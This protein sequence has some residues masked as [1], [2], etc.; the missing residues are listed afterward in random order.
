LFAQQQLVRIIGLFLLLSHRH[1]LCTRAEGVFLALCARAQWVPDG[2]PL[3]RLHPAP[4][5]SFLLNLTQSFFVLFLLQKLT[6]NGEAGAF[7]MGGY[8]DN[9]PLCA[10]CFVPFLSEKLISVAQF[11]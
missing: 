8:Y 5:D 10:L 11:D 7:S 1:P 2:W 3:M 9:P 6:E 4:A